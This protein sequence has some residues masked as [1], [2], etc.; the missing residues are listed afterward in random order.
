M[1]NTINF[2]GKTVEDAITQAN[3]QLG[4]TS[5]QLQYEIIEKGSAGFLGIGSHDALIRVYQSTKKEEDFSIND[6]YESVPEEPKVETPSYEKKEAPVEKAAKPADEDHRERPAREKVQGN[7]ETGAKAAEVAKQFLTDIF[8]TMDITVNVNSTYEEDDS[9][10]SIELSGDDMGIIIGKR[11]A[12]LDSIQYLTN[13][14]VNRKVDIYTRVKVDTEDYR[15]RRKETLEN[16]AKNTA[17]KAKRTRRPVALESMNPYERRIIHYA[18]QHDTGV[19]T[20]SEGEEP[21]RHVVVVPK[22]S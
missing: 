12:T 14:A 5:D 13:L 8:A 9:T 15:R 17:Y 16:L 6:E 4:I 1:S 3:V 21:Y 7:A 22:R 11:G 2:T 20:H 10:L 19:T 18:L